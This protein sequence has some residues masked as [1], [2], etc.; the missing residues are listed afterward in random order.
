[1]EEE[2]Q[3]L[4]VGRGLGDELG[5]MWNWARM[6]G[7]GMKRRGHGKI[8]C[9]G[10]ICGTWHWLHVGGG[11]WAEKGIQDASGFEL[12][13]REMLGNRSLQRVMG[14]IETRQF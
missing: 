3:R 5:R 1:M 11:G 6:V 8:C 2:G 10:G 12:A 13:V 4:Q 7:V 9:I 14:F